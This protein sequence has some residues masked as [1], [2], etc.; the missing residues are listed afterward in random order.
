M[1]KGQLVATF[2]DVEKVSCMKDKITD[3]DADIDDVYQLLLRFKSGLSCHLMVDVIARPAIRIFRLCGTEGT[4]EWDHSRNEIRVFEA[5]EGA[6]RIEKLDSGQI[7]AGYIHQEEPYVNEV[8][9]FLAAI[10]GERPWPNPFREDVKVLDILLAA[11]KSSE[12]G[13]AQTLR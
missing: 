5:S 8:A 7:E 6:W 4:L 3:L 12:T 1:Y 9:D 10:K 2:G 13:V 11:E